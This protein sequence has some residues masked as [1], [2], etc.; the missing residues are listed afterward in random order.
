MFNTTI[1]MRLAALLAM[2]GWM[3]PAQ[4]QVSLGRQGKDYDFSSAALTR[5]NRMGSA[6]PGSCAEGETFFLSSAAAGLNLYGCSGGAWTL[7]GDGGATGQNY[8]VAF[9]AQTSRQVP[10][11]EHGISN[12]SLGSSCYESS[13]ERVEGYGLRLD[14]VTFEAIITFPTPFTGTCVLIAAG[15]PAVSGG[16]GSGTPTGPAG[17]D[18]AGTYPNPVLAASGVT[19]GTYGGSTQIPRIQVDA[20]GR[21]VAI[22]PITVSGGGG[23]A[24]VGLSLP[25]EFA[26]SGSPLTSSGTIAGAWVS[27]A[28]GRVL[29]APA[30]AA[31]SPS[32]RALAQ[33]DLPLMTGDAGSGGARGAVPPPAAGDAA[34]GKFL[35]ADGV[36]EIPAGGGAGGSYTAGDGIQILAGQISV[37]ASV[38]GVV[39]NGSQSLVFGSIAQSACATQTITAPGATIGDRVV[40]GFPA[41]L[42]DGVTG[43]MLIPATDTIAVR[44]CKITTGAA[45]VSGL[46]FN[47][48]IIRGR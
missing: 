22:T 7:L 8:A 46:T 24:S 43:I 40:A 11:S 6:L 18:L 10:A 30:A 13:G 34:A 12:G 44:L 27:Q 14:P 42:P 28:A 5:P 17:G 4:T 3:L 29:A 38:P 19:A 23:V 1:P 35:R 32:F 39:L 26:V 2:T 25:A 36:W 45:D 16:S 20:K 9:I 47:Y 41:T 15:S 48:Q 21:I 33:S 37:D 31:G